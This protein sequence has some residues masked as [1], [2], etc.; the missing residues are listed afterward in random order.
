[1]KRYQR[2]VT[3][4]IQTAVAP[5]GTAFEITT[6]T[7]TIVTHALNFQRAIEEELK[8]GCTLAEARESVAKK[9]P[10]IYQDWVSEEIVK[11]EMARELPPVDL[12]GRPIGVT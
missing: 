11:D 4:E 7:K 8:A 2:K 3:E 5:N 6:R 9:H 12:I 10:S 1:M